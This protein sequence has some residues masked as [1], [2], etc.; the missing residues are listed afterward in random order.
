[1]P[2]L[3]H[4]HNVCTTATTQERRIGNCLEPLEVVA[5]L[6][7]AATHDYRHPG[8]SNNFLVKTM[9]TLALRYND[10][11]VLENFHAASAFEVVSTQKYN[12]FARLSPEVTSK[13]RKTIIRYVRC[14]RLCCCCSRL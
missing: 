14:V 6:F 1:V 2:R 5:L 10:D 3:Y 11:S 4:C 8:V 12:I 9:S 13:M 7:A